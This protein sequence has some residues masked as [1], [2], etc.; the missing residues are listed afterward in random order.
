L[1]RAIVGQQLSTRAA[2][3]IFS[4]IAAACA[5]DVSPAAVDALPDDT[6]RSAGLS[7]Q[8]LRYLR[9]LTARTRS[10]HLDFDRLRLLGDEEALAHLTT[11]KGVGVWTAQM[12]LIFA[13]RRPDVYFPVADLGLRNAIERLY[14]FTQ[15]PSRQQ[16]LTI[17]APW[18]PYSSIACWYLWRSLDGEAALE[19]R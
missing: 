9:D 18:R 15:P 19:T 1:L 10:G 17:A 8:K 5:G 6:L 13:L 12:F 4:R 3:T 16:M 7:P 14:G 11:V 2:S